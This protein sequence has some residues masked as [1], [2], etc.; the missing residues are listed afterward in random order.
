VYQQEKLKATRTSLSPIRR[1][2]APCF[3]NYIKGC[4]RFAAASD[5]SLPVA[6]LWSVVLSGYS[7]FLHHQNSSPWYSWNIAQSGV[8]HQWVCHLATSLMKSS[9][10]WYALYIVATWSSV[11]LSTGWGSR[12]CAWKRFS[13]LR[14]RDSSSVI[15]WPVASATAER[16]FSV[17][18]RLK[19]YVRS[20]MKNDRL[21]PLVLM[22]THQDFELDLYK[23]MEVFVSVKTRRADCEQF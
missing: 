19:T 20:T 11:I 13:D 6:C 18:R 22:H 4:T 15:K 16:S 23:A 9:N 17:L 1:G 2:L 5:K 21:S 10:A 3:V 12:Y 14:R 8:K 7:G